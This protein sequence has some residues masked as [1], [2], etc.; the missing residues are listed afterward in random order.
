ML[1]DKLKCLHMLHWAIIFLGI[2]QEGTHVSFD[3]GTFI[4]H[5]Y[6][7]KNSFLLWN[8][9]M[10]YMET[11]DKIKNLSNFFWILL[12]NLSLLLK[13]MSI[14]SVMPSNQ[15]ILCHPLLLLPSIF[16]SIGSSPVSQLFASDDQILEL[17]LQH[18]SFQWMFRVGFL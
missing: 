15:L 12:Y 16:S 10:M 17:Q 11:W 14:E 2:Y 8:L 7:S 18:Q 6:S 5:P 4:P 3:L 9:K 13:L 1:L